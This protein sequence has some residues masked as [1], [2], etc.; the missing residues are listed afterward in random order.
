MER[1]YLWFI[2]LVPFVLLIPI[3][4]YVEGIPEGV[5]FLLI[6]ACYVPLVFASAKET[7]VLREQGVDLNKG[8]PVGNVIAKVL[9][10]I[11]LGGVIWLI[12]TILIR[13]N[14]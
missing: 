4:R 12:C 13:H 8:S 10:V 1:K 7:K 2:A 5:M 11:F 9:G 14:A 3:F 6:T